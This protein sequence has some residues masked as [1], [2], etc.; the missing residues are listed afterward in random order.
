MQMHYP[1]MSACYREVV[2]EVI[3][4]HSLRP[5]GLDPTN[6]PPD[7]TENRLTILVRTPVNIVLLQ[8]T[9]QYHNYIDYS[10]L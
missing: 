4:R 8:A 5:E 10:Y 2:A 1:T 7:A 6:P 9:T 3:P